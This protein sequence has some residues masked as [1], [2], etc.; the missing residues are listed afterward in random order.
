MAG[1]VP[2]GIE[3]SR[4][5]AARESLREVNR[6]PRAGIFSD[7]VSGES[8][9]VMPRLPECRGAGEGAG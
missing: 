8:R 1:A 6:P 9:E 5:E 7:I 3:R 4:G 2:R